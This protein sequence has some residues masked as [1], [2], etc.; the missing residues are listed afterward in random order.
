[1]GSAAVADHRARERFCDVVTVQPAARSGG[2]DEY[3]PEY[4]AP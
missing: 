2:I 4:V 3:K 1:M